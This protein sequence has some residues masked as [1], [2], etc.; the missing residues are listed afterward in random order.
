MSGVGR[1]AG[2]LGFTFAALFFYPLAAALEGDP[3][4]LQWQPSHSVEALTALVV[5][6]AVLGGALRV[7]LPQQQ[8]WA[9]VT[10]AVLA[11]VPLASLGAGASRQVPF[12]GDLRLAWE[13]PF[14]RYGVTFVAAALPVAGLTW[15]PGASRRVLEWLLLVLSPVS[16]VVV[17]ALVRPAFQ[18]AVRIAVERPPAPS[19]GPS[20]PSVLALLFDELSFSYLFDEEGGGEIRPEFPHFRSFATGAT[21]YLAVRS[22]GGSTM[23]AIPGYLTGQS[24]D[25][26]HP[27]RR[28]LRY[29]R[30]G[31]QGHIHVSDA[32]GLLH[33]ARQAGLSP[34]ILGYYFAYCD[35]VGTAVDRCRSFSFY[36]VSTLNL[37]FSLVDPVLTTVILWPRQFPLGLLKHRA[38]GR[39]QRALVAATDRMLVPPITQAYPAFRLVHFSVPHLPFVFTEEGY[40]PPFD[41][42]ASRPDTAYVAQVRYIDRWLGEILGRMRQDGSYDRTTIVVFADHGFRSGRRERDPRHVPFLVKSA[43]Q[44]SGRRIAASM[45]GEQLLDAVVAE[46]CAGWSGGDPARSPEP[47]EPVRGTT[48]TTTDGPVH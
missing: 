33:T 28:G 12:S 19:S 47:A 27:D 3:Y 30:G 21:T 24:F 38:F 18:P 10:L 31:A 2:W 35:L 8:R 25:Q 46:S 36:N 5:L 20:C 37:R 43:G 17:V 14:W 34:E 15:W 44:R 1:R 39:Y 16:L 22:P 9:T 7:V 48:S 4:Y 29:V 42:L 13:S 41:P 40:D 11:V 6:A 26:V 32:E 45:A 23:T